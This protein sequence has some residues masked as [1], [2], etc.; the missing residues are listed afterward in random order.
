MRMVRTM[1]PATV[2][3]GA[4][5]PG[6]GPE[7]GAGPAARIRLATADGQGRMAPTET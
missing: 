1:P 5:Q 7:A 6:H 4:R 2:N 3:A